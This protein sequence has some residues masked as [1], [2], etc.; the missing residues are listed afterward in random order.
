M[1]KMNWFVKV[2]GRELPT[3]I[4]DLMG[5]TSTARKLT[6]TDRATKDGKSIDKIVEFIY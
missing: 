6:I 4:T 3:T 5:M 2:E 1:K